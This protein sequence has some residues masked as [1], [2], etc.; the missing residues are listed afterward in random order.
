VWVLYCTYIPLDGGWCKVRRCQ[1]GCSGQAFIVLVWLLEMIDGIDFML[2]LYLCK[3]C[4]VVL[5]RS[6]KMP[7]EDLVWGDVERG[8]MSM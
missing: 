2:D 7:L 1:S 4:C 3:L 5:C 6:V 8:P